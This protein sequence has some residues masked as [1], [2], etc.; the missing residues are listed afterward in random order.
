[1]YGQ[2]WRYKI[3]NYRNSIPLIFPCVE[4]TIWS[5][6]SNTLT[7]PSAR[8]STVTTMMALMWCARAVSSFFKSTRGCDV[9]AAHRFV[10][11]MT[12]WK[13]HR[14]MVEPSNCPLVAECDQFALPSFRS[15]VR[16]R[17]PASI[18]QRTATH[19][20]THQICNNRHSSFIQPNFRFT[21]MTTTTGDH[22]LAS[23][24]MDFFSPH[25][26]FFIFR[27]R[28]VSVWSWTELS[29]CHLLLSVLL[30]C[31]REIFEIW[32]DAWNAMWW[33]WSIAKYRIRSKFEKIYCHYSLL[34]S[35]SLVATR[36][37]LAFNVLKCASN[38]YSEMKILFFPRFRTILMVGTR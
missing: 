1:M 16:V 31:L 28:R 21:H 4:L 8:P 29:G 12:T 20:S 13:T 10:P 27:I 33:P 22:W 15:C 9:L 26:F 30:H 35:A 6:E 38:D 14:N 34:L 3:A 24:W 7:Q 19:I 37:W 32:W 2:N 17:A 5:I 23:I 25:F 11:P 18:G 36:Q